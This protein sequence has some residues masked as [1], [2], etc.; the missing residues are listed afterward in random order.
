MTAIPPTEAAFG[1]LVER[2]RR[3]LHV[4]CYR[5]LASFDEAEDA[6]QETSL[7]AWRSRNSFDGTRFRAWLYRIA[8]NVCLDML[9]RT[10]RR[11]TTMRNFSEVPW[12]QP[13]PDQVL[14]EVAPSDEQ[15][16]AVVVERETIELAFLAAMQVVP[17]RQ[18][19]ALIASDVLGWPA[20]ET[21][22]P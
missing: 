16:D 18:R 5:M 22:T 3:E 8:T 21:A 9:R 12:L 4:H 6:V 13:Y 17:P 11:L 2:H 7:R 15:P 19:A 14:D 1:E 10:S 20:K